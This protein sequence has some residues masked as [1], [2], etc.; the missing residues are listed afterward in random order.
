MVVLFILTEVDCYNLCIGLC[1][2][3]DTEHPN[4]LKLLG[5]CVESVP[6]LT[7]LELCINVSILFF[8]F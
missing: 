5:C 4:V 1:L 7:V 3:R 6:Y 8:L 2:F